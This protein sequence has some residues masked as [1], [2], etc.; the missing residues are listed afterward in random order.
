MDDELGVDYV[1]DGR[2]RR[3]GIDCEYR[4]NF[5]TSG[6]TAMWAGQFDEDLTDVLELGMLSRT[7]AGFDPQLTGEDRKS[8]QNGD[9]CA[10]GIR[11]SAGKV[12]LEPIHLNVASARDRGFQRAI[13]PILIISCMLVLPTLYLGEYLRDHTGNRVI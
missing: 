6:R 1:L 7:V 9:E 4:S 10:A 2:I 13:E 11:L 8:L 3:F 5:G 12:L